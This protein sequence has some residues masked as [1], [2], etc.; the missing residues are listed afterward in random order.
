MARDTITG[1]ATVI[2]SG[3][4]PVGGGMAVVAT[5]VAANMSRGFTRSP[6]VVMTAVAKL[7]CSCENSAEVAT[8]ALNASV[9]AGEGKTCREVVELTTG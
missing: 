8:V 9:S 4:T 3:K 5:V 1:N 6:D 2:K 7:W